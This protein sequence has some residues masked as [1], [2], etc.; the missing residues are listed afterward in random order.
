MLLLNL[1]FE[2]MEVPVGHP[3]LFSGCPTIRPCN[4]YRPYSSAG[5]LLCMQLI[6]KELGGTVERKNVSE[7]G[8]FMNQV[9]TECP[10]FKGLETRQ[11]V[12]L[13]HG[14]SVD[15]VAEGLRCVAKSL[16]HIISTI[17]DTERRLYG[18]Q[19]HDLTD[20]GRKMLHNF[21]FDI[22]DL[23]GA[24]TLEKRDQ[25]CIDHI[26]R[27][28]VRDKI[29]LIL[30]SGGADT[31]VCAALLHKALLQGDDSLRVQIIHINNSFLSKDESEQIVTTLQQLGL[32]HRFFYRQ[33]LLISSSNQRFDVSNCFGF[34]NQVCLS[35]MLPPT[36]M[37]AKL[38][39]YVGLLIQKKNVELLAIL[40]GQG[41][42]RPDLVR[43]SDFMIG[44]PAIPDTH[45]AQEV[46]DKM[47]EAVFTV[48]GIFRVLYDLTAKPPGTTEWE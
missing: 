35:M 33:W 34:F 2:N 12:L 4:L 6:N 16:R 21:L 22:C 8:Q 15:K 48:P 7:D 28:V 13:T 31:T 1:T 47:N 40:L 43:E 9:E 26:R 24:F 17:A 5:N 36:W 25:H 39:R 38:F 46:V 32:N 37:A 30:V 41:A 29:V 27:M 45:L 3:S 19:F 14:D 10:L 23:K 44:L 42:L 18:V 11:M 20:N